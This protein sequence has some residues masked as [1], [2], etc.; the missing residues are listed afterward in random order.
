MKKLRSFLKYTVTL[1]VAGILLWFVFRDIDLN[2]MFLKLRQADFKWIVL[3][4]FFALIAHILRAYRWNLLLKPIGYRLNLFRTFLAVMVGY[5]ANLLV[6]RMGEVT[7]CGILK[8]TDD[9]AMTSSLGTVV[10][11][12][13]ID[14]LV[15]L[16]IV[17]AAFVVEFDLLNDYFTGFFEDKLALIGRN[18]LLVYIV[19]GLGG[20]GLIT[21]FLVLR[22][23]KERI[24]KNKIFI[25]VRGFLRE[26]VEGLTSI[27]RV[28]HM[29]GFILSTIMIWILYYAMSYVV[30]FA[31]PETSSLSLLAGLSILAMGS[32]G[33][34]A[35]VQGG[36]GAYHAFVASV[37]V[38]YGIDKEDGVLFATLLHTSQVAMVIIVGGISFLISLIIKK[39][40]TRINSPE[41][42]PSSVTETS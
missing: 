10:A 31:L 4:I 20:A 28:D 41:F 35:P 23:H 33:M 14:F 2:Q 32:L 19:A 6:P 30:V 17:A 3:S 36:I 29:I 39:K 11:E 21:A 38:L 8:K 27:R 37:L 34:A 1:A 42:R 5:F 26:L 25:K 13:I 22:H 24:K 7:R 15:L 18:L 9:V 12:R 40:S 16:L